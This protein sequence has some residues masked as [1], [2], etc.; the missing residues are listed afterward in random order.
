MLSPCGCK[1][2]IAHVHRDCIQGWIDVHGNRCEMCKQIYS[3][4][5]L[6]SVSLCKDLTVCA[7]SLVFGFVG[8]VFGAFLM[9]YAMEDGDLVKVP[10]RTCT[11]LWWSIVLNGAYTSLKCGY[12]GAKVTTYYILWVSRD[13][14]QFVVV[15]GHLVRYHY[16]TL[17]M[18][19]AFFRLRRHLRRQVEREQYFERRE[20][21]I[22]RRQEAARARVDEVGRQIERNSRLIARNSRLIARNDLIIEALVSPRRSRR[23]IEATEARAETIE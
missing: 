10:W 8:I 3:A 20:A 4:R 23:L 11:I 6:T 5:Y 19:W 12:Y 2:T 21:D 18:Q 7:L 9:A 16:T 1:G 14:R 22:Y 15:A 17:R 13:P